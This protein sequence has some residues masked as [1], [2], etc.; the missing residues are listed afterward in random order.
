MPPKK[1]TLQEADSNA[2]ASAPAPKNPKRAEDQENQPKDDDVE[3]V[4]EQQDKTSDTPDEP[5]LDHRPD[6]WICVD[7]PFWDFEY[8]HTHGSNDEASDEVDGDEDDGDGDLRGRYM[9]EVVEQKI[10]GTP[11]AEKPGYKWKMVWDAWKQICELRV[12]EDYCDP[13]NF[14][15]YIYNDFNS[16]GIVALIEMQVS[17]DRGCWRRVC[18]ADSSV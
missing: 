5:S 7:Q 12:Q 11:A 6:E 15:M 10:W 16:Y 4:G 17:L 8:A 18:A 14:D 2:N 1:R 9:R 13:D 3:V